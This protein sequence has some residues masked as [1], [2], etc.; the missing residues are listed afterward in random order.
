[1]RQFAVGLETS[2][3]ATYRALT[4]AALFRYSTQMG[5]L[6]ATMPLFCSTRT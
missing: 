6:Q 3:F 4:G 1:M 2:W 5:E